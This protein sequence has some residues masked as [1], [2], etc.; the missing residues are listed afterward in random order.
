DVL[1]GP[2][3]W[4][5]PSD[6][7]KVLTET[8]TERRESGGSRIVGQEVRDLFAESCQTARLGHDDRTARVQMLVEHVEH[9]TCGGLREVQHPRVVE[10]APAAGPARGDVNPFTRGFKHANRGLS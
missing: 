5:A 8:A 4:R 7:D 3:R 10:C 1:A 9:V 2:D 6:H